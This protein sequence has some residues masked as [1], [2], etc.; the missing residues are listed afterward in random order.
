MKKKHFTGISAAYPLIQKYKLRTQEGT[1]KETRFLLILDD[2]V[3]RF[4]AHVE[5]KKKLTVALEQAYASY[6][7]HPEEIQICE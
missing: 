6:K 3:F 2:F 5:N 4:S 1:G 7:E